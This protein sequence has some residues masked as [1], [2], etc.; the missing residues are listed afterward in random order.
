MVRLAFLFIFMVGVIVTLQAADTGLLTV[1]STPEGIEVWLEDKYIGDTPI[2]EKKLKPGRYSIKLVDPIR[3]TSIK[4]EV[5]V[6]AGD[7]TYL[8]KTMK[9]KYGT[10]QISTEPAG[11]D[12]YLSTPLGKSPLS[13]EFMNPGKYRLEIRHPNPAYQGAT[14]DIIIPRG[15][16]VTLNKTL[17]VNNPFDKKALVRL[18]LGAGAIASFVWAIVE[19]G[20]YGKFN[21]RIKMD[22]EYNF[23]TDDD[24]SADKDERSKAAVKRT[25]GII[26]G[27]VCVVGFEIVAFF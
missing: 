8:E 12:I 4:E 13:N 9:T 23:L 2:I 3:H 5:F 22:L 21:E 14:E 27:S 6:Q 16:T 20:N 24:R 25:L 10:L 7:V 15:E 17:E 18:G 26:F 1:K 11:A 19:Q